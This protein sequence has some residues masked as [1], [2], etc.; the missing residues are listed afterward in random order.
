M[1]DTP[2]DRCTDPVSSSV[3]LYITS[4]RKKAERQIMEVTGGLGNAIPTASDLKR[5]DEE[6]RIRVTCARWKEGKEGCGSG[7]LRMNSYEDAP[8]DILTHQAQ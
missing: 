1:V 5:F 3:L 4:L 7:K 8:F 6:V 2:S